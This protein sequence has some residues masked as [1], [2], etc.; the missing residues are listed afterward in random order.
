MAAYQLIGWFHQATVES[1][2][3]AGK[4]EM[5]KMQFAGLS[6]S[7]VGSK[8]MYQ[9]LQ[10]YAMQSPFRIPELA[11]NSKKLLA[12]GFA[13]GEVIPKLRMLRDVAM[14]DND[15]LGRL[16]NAY[17]RVAAK[18]RA[19]LRELNM[20]IYAG[21]PI[22]QELAK[23]MGVTESKIYELC[24]KGQIGF[25]DVDKALKTLTDDGGRFHD[26]MLNQA[27]TVS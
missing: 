3:F 18:G 17:E 13:T 21:V 1:V 4:L 15:K 12:V 26:M 22:M 24:S 20:F 8:D 5:L 7:I 23:N 25:S 16:T 9:Q 11:E 14:G 27:K 10:D 6:G 2:Q 19:S